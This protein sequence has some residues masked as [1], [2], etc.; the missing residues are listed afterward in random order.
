MRGA[1]V[2]SPATC[3][4]S[5]ADSYIIRETVYNGNVGMMSGSGLVASLFVSFFSDRSRLSRNVAFTRLVAFLGAVV[6]G[7]SSLFRVFRLTSPCG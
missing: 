3:G 1:G 7:H 2:D 5:F 6:A 4:G